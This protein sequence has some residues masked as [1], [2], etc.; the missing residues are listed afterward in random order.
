M[1]K[2]QTLIRE[3]FGKDAG[4]ILSYMKELKSKSLAD[5]MRFVDSNVYSFEFEFI[6]ENEKEKKDYWLYIWRLKR[7]INLVNSYVM[8]I[9]K[10][11]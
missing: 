7:N 3:R 1:Y 10:G 6:F 11:E 2:M 9:L 4:A 5:S 8:N